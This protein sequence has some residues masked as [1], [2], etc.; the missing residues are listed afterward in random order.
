MTWQC[1]NFKLIKLIFPISVVFS[2][3]SHWN[4]NMSTLI[5]FR[6][7]TFTP[8]PTPLEKTF[9]FLKQNDSALHSASQSHL[10]RSSINAIVDNANPISNT[11]K[12]PFRVR[13]FNFFRATSSEFWTSFGVCWVS[14]RD[15]LDIWNI[16]SYSSFVIRSRTPDSNSRIKLKGEVNQ[17]Q[18]I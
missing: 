3:Y 12:A 17:L 7:T 5:N 10:N 2:F 6:T 13:K 9:T 8:F 4:L 15:F 14:A 1:I 18:I 16:L 11:I